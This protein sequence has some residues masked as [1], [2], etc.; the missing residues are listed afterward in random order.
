[1]ADFA[2]IGAAGYI[3]PRHM[4]AISA[5]GNRLVAALDRNDSVGVIDRYFPEAAFFTEAERFDRHLEKLRRNGQPAHYLSVCTPNYLH[6]AHIRFGLR[7]QMNV[8]CEKPVVLQPDN[9]L[10]LQQLE[11]ESGKKVSTVFQLRLHPAI[12]ALRAQVAAAPPG[13]TFDIDLTYITARGK[14][15][16]ASWKGD[17]QKSGGIATNIG[18]HFFDLLCWIFGPLRESRVHLN[19]HDRAAGFLQLERA[20]VRWFLSINAATLPTEASRQGQMVFREMMVD[21]TPVDF[22][23]GGEDLITAAYQEIFSGGGTGLSDALPALEL[24]YAI[25]QAAPQGPSGDQHPM[26][27]LP[28]SPHPFGI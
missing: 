26:A 21:G 4:Q 10:L 7:Q 27:A 22:S 20:R 24:V 5:T 16:Y 15:Y 6:D 18:I 11:Q 9:L 14:W 19:T 3:A 2:L 23:Y 25:R 17:Q 28:L 13:K 8:I 12:Q 1:M